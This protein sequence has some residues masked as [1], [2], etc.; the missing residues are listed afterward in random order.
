MLGMH[1]IE[2][3]ECYRQLAH[4]SGGIAQVIT[5]KL[6]DEAFGHAVV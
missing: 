2:V 5:A 6:I 4:H 1:L 3:L